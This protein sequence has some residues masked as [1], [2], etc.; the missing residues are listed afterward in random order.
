MLD[1][2][3]AFLEKFIVDFTW[4]RLVI[5]LMILLLTAGAFYSYER[6]TDSFQLSRIE[7]A[8]ILLRELAALRPSVQNDSTLAPVYLMIQKQLVAVLQ[9]SPTPFSMPPIV[10]KGLAGAAPWMIVSLLFLV[11][12]IRGTSDP[13]TLFGG[14]MF[15]II[16]GLIGMLIPDSLGPNIVYLVYPIG[17]FFLIAVVL[18]LWQRFKKKA[19]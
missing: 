11:A 6:F 17:H 19:A 15:M 10:L 18:V 5:F 13:N 3:F 9:S 4:K 12:V 14:V 16:F 2:L 8:T 7:R 1:P